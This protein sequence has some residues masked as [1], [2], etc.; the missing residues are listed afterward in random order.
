MTEDE[1]GRTEMLTR[2]AEEAHHLVFQVLAGL[3]YANFADEEAD[4]SGILQGAL[5][6]VLDYAF[7]AHEDPMVLEHKLRGMFDLLLPQV[8]MRKQQRDLGSATEAGHA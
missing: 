1:E 7:Q 5:L 3:R 8:A 2:T 4:C 6:G